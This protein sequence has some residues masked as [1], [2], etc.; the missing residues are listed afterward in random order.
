LAD[1]F[2][3][4]KGVGKEDNWADIGKIETSYSRELPTHRLQET[5]LDDRSS[6]KVSSKDQVLFGSK[7]IY[8][9]PYPAK[10]KL[11]TDWWVGFVVLP[12]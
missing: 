6:R 3:E 1:P 8:N 11:Q 4:P 7:G 9:T 10:D 2:S 5:K 12:A